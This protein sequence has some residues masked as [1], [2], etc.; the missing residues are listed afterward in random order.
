MDNLVLTMI[1]Q[2]AR[3][4]D[5]EVTARHLE[6]LD[7]AHSYYAENRVGP[8]F[9]NL[10]RNVGASRDEIEG[11]FPNGIHSVYVWVGIP[12]MTTASGCKPVAHIE[13]ENAR[14]VYLDHNATTY[15]RDEVASLLAQ[16]AV[17]KSTFGN[18]SSSNHAGQQAHGD[19]HRARQK[20]AGVLGVA[21]EEVTFTGCG[22]EA[23]NLAIKGV[24]FRHL[25]ERKHL[26]TAAIEHPSVLDTMQFLERIG[27]DVT[28]LPIDRDGLVSPTDL[29]AAITADTILVA[30]MAVNN[31]IGTINPMADLGAIC[32]QRGVPLFC[33]A[34]QAF[35]KIPLDPKGCGISMLSLSGHKIYGPKGV[36]ALY[37]DESIELEPLI[38]GGG[39]E[40]GLRSGTEN[41]ESIVAT[42]L[43]A[44]LITAEREREHDRLLALR[45]HFLDRLR[46][47]EPDAVI[48][49]SLEHRIPHNL[50]V[51]FR[52]VDS[53]SI[54][55]SL[56]HIGVYVSSGSAC[57]AG[58]KEASHVIRALGAD[59]GERGTIRFSF[60]LRS[61]RDDI[62]Y[63]FEHLGTI[64]HL[65]RDE[66]PI[67]A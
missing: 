53:G 47:I 56:N 39:Q 50:N 4:T 61:Q 20:I 37:V 42:G 19:V 63:L 3:R 14:Q 12:I 17:D 1:H 40:R 11:L 21:P 46:A 7:Y 2:M 67:A 51:G 41:V 31:E 38:H 44:E 58:A 13:V 8:L 30:I 66:D 55:L 24:A 62:D 18:P 52:G 23:N 48:N 54:L 60:G 9:P 64:L 5:T 45:E 36:G 28:Y 57:H 33:D 49:G 26:I 6:I 15:L 34:I 29:R 22:S 35:G 32:R 43:A 59:R 65:L 16:R 10:V 25:G 27:F